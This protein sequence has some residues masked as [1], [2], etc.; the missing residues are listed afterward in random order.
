MV[1]NMKCENEI[2]ANSVGVD[3]ETKKR[4]ER[5]E[6]D[7][8]SLRSGFAAN[9]P[10]QDALRAIRQAGERY[11][12]KKCDFTVSDLV[13]QASEKASD[14]DPLYKE[15]YGVLSVEFM[16]KQKAQSFD[17]TYHLDGQ[18]RFSKDNGP[19]QLV[20]ESMI[21]HCVS[22]WFKDIRESSGI[23]E[24]KKKEYVAEAPR[25]RAFE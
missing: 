16:R 18:F 8:R 21:G 19:I 10:L 3:E 22:G 17:I 23:V 5:F 4:I 9:K 1:K 12:L 24:L 15:P 13:I 20:D 7:E 2:L 14:A 11:K 25:R 6:A